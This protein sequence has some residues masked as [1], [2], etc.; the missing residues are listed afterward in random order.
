M[1]AASTLPKSAAA[2]ERNL[3]ATENMW[4]DD[5]FG[6]AIDPSPRWKDMDPPTGPSGPWV[7]GSS[8]TGFSR[9][10]TSTYAGSYVERPDM[11]TGLSGQPKA[12]RYP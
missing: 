7:D 5:V 10:S 11:L 12:P 9:S 3:M 4:N 6:D 2:S 8:A 1:A